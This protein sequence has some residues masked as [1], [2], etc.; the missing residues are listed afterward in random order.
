[1]DDEF[2]RLTYELLINILHKEQMDSKLV[3]DFITNPESEL[4]FILNEE[5]R[6]YTN[7]HSIDLPITTNGSKTHIVSDVKGYS[8][9]DTLLFIFII[10]GR[11]QEFTLE[12][13]INR[14][15]W[16]CL[17][18]KFKVKEDKQIREDELKILM[19][20]SNS[21]VK[22]GGFDDLVYHTYTHDIEHTYRLMKDNYKGVI[23]IMD[24]PEQIMSMRPNGIRPM[25]QRIY[26]KDHK[27]KRPSDVLSLLNNDIIYLYSI[28]IMDY[29]IYDDTSVF[30]GNTIKNSLIRMVSK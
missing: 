25:K 6:K 16:I 21:F 30:T 4:E 18:S 20:R 29:P 10:K 14:F 28:N 5:L 27:I 8:T 11:M 19:S 1:M 13:L 7:Q 2:K 9:E 15:K 24:K 17:Y 23:I 3:N 12:I 22:E 26:V